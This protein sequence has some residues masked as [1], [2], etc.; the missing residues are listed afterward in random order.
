LKARIQD[1]LA[2]ASS[3]QHQPDNTTRHVISLQHT[4]DIAQR[5]GRTRREIDILAL[6]HDIVPER[7]L[8]NLN[9]L[10]P[11]DQIT[12][13]KSH[14]CIV[15]LG[16][17]G[18]SLV[19]ILAR[20]GLGTLTIIDGDVFEE[21]NLNRQLLSSEHNLSQTK[22]SAA[23]EKILTINSS[24]HVLDHTEAMDRKNAVELLGRADIAVDCLDSV[25][26]RFVLEKAAKEAGIPM[27]SAAVAGYAG[28]LTAIFPGDRGL[29]S[30]YGPVESRPST[31]GAETVLG[32]LP[33]TV[34]LLASLESAEVVNI[35]LTGDSS[36]RNELLLI[37]LKDHHFEKVRLI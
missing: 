16:G 7:Y 35:L 15:G 19:E 30:I 11:K 4:A 23:L 14:A 20:I 22:A 36:L 9:S 32:N 27:V 1:L 10:S 31:R 3:L 8:R 34:S 12:L 13:L 17:L 21:S 33:F 26:T 37:D 5:T 28:Q 29:A 2:E 24:V 6:E 25:Q 18:G